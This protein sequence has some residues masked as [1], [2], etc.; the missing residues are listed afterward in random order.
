MGLS[1]GKRRREKGPENVSAYPGWRETAPNMKVEDKL[2]TSGGIVPEER[3]R[4]KLKGLDATNHVLFLLKQ[5]G[6]AWRWLPFWIIDR[7]PGQ[8][9]IPALGVKTG[10]GRNS[11]PM[12][13]L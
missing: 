11:R 12:A 7:V 2:Q 9:V 6:P 5:G 8:P 1:S 10:L 4:A 3:V 13:P